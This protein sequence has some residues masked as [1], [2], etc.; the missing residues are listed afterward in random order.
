MFLLDNYK[1]EPQLVEVQQTAGDLNRN[2]KGNILRGAINPVAST[3]QTIELEGQHAA[4][5]SHV[6]VPSIYLKDDE[7][8]P[9]DHATKPKESNQQSA[10]DSAHEATPRPQPPQQPQQPIVPS[11]RFR[12]VRA[13]VKGGKRILGDVKRAVTGKV[14]QEQH[15]AK[16]TINRVHG[17][18]LKITPTESLAPG[19]Y[20]VVEMLGKEGMNLYVWDFGVNPNAPPNANPW[21][22]DTKAAKPLGSGP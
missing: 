10:S 19:E 18:W 5:Q 8:T 21:K 9:D 6:G 22:P 7:G 13:D 2:M 15:F 14:S 1:G 11:D 20:A 4:V 12:I 16:S 3:K 17:G